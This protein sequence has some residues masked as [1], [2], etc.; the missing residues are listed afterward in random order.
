[1]ELPLGDLEYVN[2][3]S[4]YEALAVDD[5]E[6]KPFIIRCKSGKGEV[7]LMN[8]WAGFGFQVSGFE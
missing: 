7:F 6:M 1:M 8:W 4:D 3:A 5:E 2:P